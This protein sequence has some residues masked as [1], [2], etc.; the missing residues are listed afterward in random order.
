[1][2]IKF[3]SDSFQQITYLDEKVFAPV[4]RA[5]KGNKIELSSYNLFLTFECD[6]RSYWIVRDKQFIKD[7]LIGNYLCAAAGPIT[8]TSILNLDESKFTECK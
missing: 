7:Q 8:G 1:L 2:Y 5:D 3:Y 4:L 6:C